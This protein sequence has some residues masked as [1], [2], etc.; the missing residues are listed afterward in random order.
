[1]S[2]LGTWLPLQRGPSHHWT[3]RADIFRLK[4]YFEANR[5]IARE[6]PPQP[7]VTGIFD[8]SAGGEGNGGGWELRGSG[9]VDSGTVM[10]FGVLEDVVE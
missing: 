2:R 10:V 1:M 9:G 7:P 5:N 6:G 3:R 4:E 8:S